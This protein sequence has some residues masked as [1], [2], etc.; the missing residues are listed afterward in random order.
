PPHRARWRCAP[1]PG[2]PRRPGRGRDHH[3]VQ[4]ERVEGG[5]G[6]RTAAR[7]PPRR[8][9]LGR[10][11]VLLPPPGPTPR[12]PD[13]HSAPVEV[14]H[15]LGAEESQPTALPTGPDEPGDLPRQAGARADP[16]GEGRRRQGSR[17]PGTS[18]PAV[19]PGGGV[20]GGRGVRAISLRLQFESTP[21]D[22]SRT[23]PNPSHL[24]QQDLVALTVSWTAVVSIPAPVAG[25]R[26]P[27]DGRGILE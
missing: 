3:D 18:A 26:I 24:L 25:R 2:G 1:A 19:A 20:L 22:P 7:T 11:A 27:P 10:V 15:T 9:A 21:S 6:A 14:L 5:A 12:Q 17:E 4:G 13:R 23:Q 16:H 8:R